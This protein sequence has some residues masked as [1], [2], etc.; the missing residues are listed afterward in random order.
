MPD[1][2]TNSNDT[3]RIESN[4]YHNENNISNNNINSNID[5]ET[6]SPYNNVVL[7]LDDGLKYPVPD[8]SIMLMSKTLS[9]MMYD[10]PPTQ[11][12]NNNSNDNNDDDDNIIHIEIH[13]TDYDTLESLLEFCHHFYHSGKYQRDPYTMQLL[14]KLCL[15]DGG[16]GEENETENENNNNDGTSRKQNILNKVPQLGDDWE[17]TFINSMT[18][19]Q[20][21]NILVL[22]DYLGINYLK[23]I[24]GQQA[25][26]ILERKTVSEL[27][28]LFCQPQDEFSDVEKQ[29][30]SAQFCWLLGNDPNTDIDKVL[31]ASV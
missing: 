25:S 3:I 15:V 31:S 27:K 30:L 9:D 19:Q 21:F 26:A 10:L 6:F 1:I 17:Q 5:N 7:M 8:H 20:L 16:S 14:G 18:L 29:Q 13:N 4:T 22:A 24:V 23:D 12:D 2:K 28:S 11:L